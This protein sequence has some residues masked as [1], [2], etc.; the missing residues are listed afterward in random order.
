MTWNSKRGMAALV[1]LAVAAGLALTV[2]PASANDSLL[3]GVTIPAG[4]P[5]PIIINNG[6]PSG[7]IQLFYT[8]TAC[9]VGP[10][11]QFNLNLEDVAGRGASPPYP[12]TV[13]FSDVGA[14]TAAQ[15]SADPASLD[16]PGAGWIAGSDVD[17]DGGSPAASAVLVTVSVTRCDWFTNGGTAIANLRESAPGR[18]HL[19]TI[20]NVNVHITAVDADACLNLYSFETNQDSGDALA[21]VVVNAK[22]NDSV[23]GTDPGQA[24]VDALVV[25]T[26]AESYS[27]DLG[28]GLDP[29]WQTNPHD[30][31][32]NATF[33]YMNNSTVQEIDPGTF[34]ITALGSGA[35]QGESLCLSNVTLPAGQTFL[36]MVHSEL[37]THF[38]GNLTVS[39]LPADSPAD[40]DFNATIFQ[41][42]SSCGVAYP[43]PSIINADQVDAPSPANPAEATSDLTFTVHQP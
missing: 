18:S 38:N 7:T 21:S 42:N 43:T 4:Q 8:A 9:S 25:N 31:P 12:V 14:G 28:V 16:V 19:N 17:G 11:A 13:S 41:P 1:A 3:S 2:S 24:S 39:L 40:F 34:N 35:P 29:E 23:T 32:G 37:N 27:F 20:S 36:A 6:V 22:T 15:A 10:F 30:N 5:V 26:C 33:T